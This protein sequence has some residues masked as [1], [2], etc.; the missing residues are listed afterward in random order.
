MNKLKKLWNENR[1]MLVLGIIV[2]LCFLV[3]AYIMFQYFFGVTTSNYGDRL[4]SIQEVVYDEMAKSSL[5][6]S[7][8]DEHLVD[9]SV[10]VRGKIIYVR[11]KYDATVA[12]SDAQKKSVEAYQTIDEKYR[13]LYDYNVTISQDATE[14]STGYCLM[15]AKN[16]SSA[17]FV[18][19]NNTPVTTEE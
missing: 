8:Q 9:F 13:N 17:S 15:G 5:E 4:E 18:W 6:S 7:Y 1:I 10:D 19:S 2:F 14:A 3:I 11:V 16:V 12:L